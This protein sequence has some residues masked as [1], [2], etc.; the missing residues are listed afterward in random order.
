MLTNMA[1]LQLMM[2]QTALGLVQQTT[3]RCQTQ[4]ILKSKGA[5]SVRLV[6]AFFW[7]KSRVCKKKTAWGCANAKTDAKTNAKK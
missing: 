1:V 3:F 4:I 6:M 5:E 7:A 2:S